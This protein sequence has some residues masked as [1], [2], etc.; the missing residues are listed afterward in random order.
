MPQETGENHFV[1]IAGQGSGG[2]IG[3]HRVRAD[4][5]C[6]FDSIAALCLGIA[7]VFCAVLVDMPVHTRGA[8]VVFLQAVHA[9]IALAGLGV[10]GEHQRQGHEG[11]AII[12]P[13]FENG[14]IIK[15]RIFRFH[16]FLTGRVLHVFREVDC[17]L[18][19]GNHGHN[20]HFILQ[21]NIGELE[22]LPQFIGDIIEFFH[23]QGHRHALI[24]AEGVHEYRHG[25]AFDVFKEQ[26]NIFIALHLGYS[27]GDFRDFQFGVNLGLY[28]L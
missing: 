28:A 9:H 18:D 23:A 14:N 2:G 10:L 4:G 1:N 20:A 11:A 3:K 8:A 16:N 5:Y 25:G 21:G 12:R 15:T 24:A 22:H 27:V 26:G 19:H 17:A 7:E 13:A 6:R